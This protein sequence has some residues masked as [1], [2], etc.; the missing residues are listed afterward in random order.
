MAGKPITEAE[1]RQ[2]VEAAGA[3][4]LGIQPVIQGNQPV[5]LFRDPQTGSSCGLYISALRDVDDVKY[6]LIRKREQFA[7]ATK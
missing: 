6:A 1:M 7:E 4:W 5:V 3:Q 2:L